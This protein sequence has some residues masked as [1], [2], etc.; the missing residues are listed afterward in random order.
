MAFNG[1]VH[2]RK[3]LFLGLVLIALL[4]AMPAAVSAAETDTVLV[5]GNIGLSMDVTASTDTI[6]FGS[7]ASGVDETGST[8]VTVVTTGS[9]WTVTA[10]DAKATSKGYMT[11]NAD[12]TGKVLANA[13]R[14]SN[15]GTTFSPL[16]SSY[17]FM[18][19][20]TAGT[21]TDTADVKQAIAVADASGTYQITVTF[22]G[23][24]S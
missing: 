23:S 24:A 15:D 11:T 17:A 9:S 14:I 1:D 3:M 10:S 13:F 12:G 4:V 8:V 18:S 21:F 7:M 19:G 16:T 22:T 5:S 2:M 20:A 6:S